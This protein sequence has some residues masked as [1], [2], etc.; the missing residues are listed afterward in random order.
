MTTAG[1][2]NSAG[3]P[4]PIRVGGCPECGMGIQGLGTD[5]ESCGWCAWPDPAVYD[6]RM[7]RLLKATKPRVRVPVNIG[8]RV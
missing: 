3:K 2:I 4:T 1:T 6:E 5:D 8:E 7:G